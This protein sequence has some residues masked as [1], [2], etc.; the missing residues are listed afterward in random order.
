MVIK[1][2]WEHLRDVVEKA[3]GIY[4]EGNGEKVIIDEKTHSFFNMY[5]LNENMLMWLLLIRMAKTPEGMK[6]VRDIMLEVVKGTFDAMD[7]YCRAGSANRISAWGSGR[8]MSL[9]LERF[10][11]LTQGQAADFLITFNLITGA[12]IAEEFTAILPWKALSSEIDFPTHI[13][14]GSKTRT[15]TV[16]RK[17][18]WMYPSKK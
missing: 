7:S 15:V 17:E 1:A 2:P 12:E 14:F 13:H 3:A 10:G 18:P 4:K 5:N 11:M 16:E 9:I 6:H 8:L